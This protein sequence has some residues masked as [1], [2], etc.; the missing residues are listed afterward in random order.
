MS[1]IDIP[2]SDVPVESLQ[3]HI[4][5]LKDYLRNA[6]EPNET[7][8][9]GST[10]VSISLQFC[11]TEEGIQVLTSL[12]ER[13]G[14]PNLPSP[15]YNFV[16]FTTV[17]SSVAPLE[18]MLD[19]GLRV[20]D[21]YEPTAGL[22]SDGERPFTLLDYVLD[23]QVYLN[24]NRK[25]LGALADKYAGGLGKRRRFIENV[26]ELLTAHGAVRASES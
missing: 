17:A 7:S 3:T 2:L 13:G 4:Q 19:A 24:R 12:L 1:I 14:D 15:I 5:Q 21:V 23:I 6:L 8:V 11:D 9:D 18:Y 20:G 10:C 26:I 16:T 22:L 25:T